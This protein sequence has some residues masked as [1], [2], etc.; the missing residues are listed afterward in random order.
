[1]VKK[2]ALPKTL[3]QKAVSLFATEEEEYAYYL[4]EYKS[5]YLPAEYNQLELL[6]HLCDESID[7]FMSITT[8]GDGKSFNYIS[9]VAYLCYHLDMGCTLLVRHFTLQDKMR[10]LVE[11]IF[12]TIKWF[13]Y[14]NDFRVRTTSDYL[15][16][17]IGDKDIFLITDIN[18]ASDLK[19]SSAVLKNFP[20]ILYD[21]FL[22]LADDYC[23]NEYEKI[24]TIYKSIDRI[25][26]RPYIKTPKCIYLA[27]PVNFD[28]PL[29]PSLK[30]YNQLQT[31]EINTM[32]QYRNVLLELRRNDS[33]NDGKN[34]RA[35]PDEYDS[36]VTGQFEFS[37]YKLVNEEQYLQV[38]QHSKSVKIKLPE[39]M[40]LHFIEKDGT[41]IL[42]VERSDNTEQ[43]CTELIDEKEDCQYLTEKYYKQSFI[44]KHEK[45]LFLYKDSFSKTFIQRDPHLMSLNL[46]KLLPSSKQTTTEETYEQVQARNYM[47]AM[48]EKY[49]L[50]YGYS[51]LRE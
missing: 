23:K 34:T 21:E 50:Q 39:K 33:R 35:F 19:Q 43:Y 32:K 41:M 18:N 37:N 29:L 30:I 28:S 7:H 5:K 31:Q 46:F 15:I 27:N 25:K 4:K 49:E 6:D 10:E 38:F 9:A 24:R 44:K 40:C 1:M 3:K 14:P 51:Y 36:D 47:K 20:I 12:S 8:R 45:G 26:D 48:Q 16:C 2:K 42:S 11:D 17:S 22:T 13:N